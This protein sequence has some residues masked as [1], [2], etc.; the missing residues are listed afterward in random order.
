MDQRRIYIIQLRILNYVLVPSILCISQM[1]QKDF[2][3]L[4][5]RDLTLEVK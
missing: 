5:K 1:L 2:D 3:F 4:V